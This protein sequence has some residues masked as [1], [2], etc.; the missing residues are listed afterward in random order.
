MAIVT[1]ADLKYEVA[2][3]P[4]SYLIR[5]YRWWWGDDAKLDFCHLFWG[6]T[7]MVLFTPFIAIL[8]TVSAP[9]WLPISLINQHT[10]TVATTAPVTVEPIEQ[11]TFNTP[12]YHPRRDKLL[13]LLTRAGSR[14]AY[15]VGSAIAWVGERRA[16]WR[17]AG[18]AARTLALILVAAGVI[19]TG[20]MVAFIVYKFILLLLDFSPHTWLLIAETIGTIIL[21]SA[22]LVFSLYL[23][24][25]GVRRGYHAQ[26]G[27]YASR[28]AVG[29]WGLFVMAYRAVKTNTCPR[30]VI[31]ED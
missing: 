30:I 29:S 4:N 19:A 27:H 2:I 23:G 1:Q 20:G 5:A 18:L 9:V 8:M 13:Q 14:V 31:K 7:G 24:A 10:R 6:T 17:K 22:I 16:F 25:L 26:I 3:S 12:K 11:V 15:A 28:P 21:G